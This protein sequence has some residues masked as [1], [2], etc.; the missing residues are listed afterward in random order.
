MSIEQRKEMLLQQ[1]DLS[2]LEGWS[3]ANHK[4]AYALLTDYYDIFSLEPGELGCTS[5]V[6]HESRVVDDEPFKERFQRISPPMVDKVR[7][8]VKEML[9]AGAIHPNQSP[10]CDAVMLVK[11]KDRG[12]CFCIDFHKFNV[13]MKK[14][15]YPLVHIQEAIESLVGVGYFS[16]LDLKAGFWQITMDK[17]SKQYTAFMVGNLG[18]FECK[19]MPFQ[20]CNAPATFQRLMQN[21]LGKLNQT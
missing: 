8:Y 5:L 1:L 17:V 13:R 7:A 3:G 15:S 10:Y 14:D 18:I 9:V 21:C 12:L 11:K 19:H 4:S 6:K 20:L 2:G 16:C